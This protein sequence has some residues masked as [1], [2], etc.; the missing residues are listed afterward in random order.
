MTHTYVHTWAITMCTWLITI[1]VV[2]TDLGRGPKNK[3]F[4]HF[5][6]HGHC[7]AMGFRIF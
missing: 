4:D 1:V 7:V 3:A 5:T 6:T 2:S